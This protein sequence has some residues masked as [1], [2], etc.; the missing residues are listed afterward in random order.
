MSA[1][2]ALERVER[3]A[4]RVK[5][6]NLSGALILGQGASAVELAPFCP[7]RLSHGLLVVN[8]DG[9]SGLG[10]MSPME[11]DEAA[12]SGI[13]LMGPDRLDIARAARDGAP[14]ALLLETAIRRALQLI[15]IAGGDVALA[16]NSPSGDLSEALRVLEKESW[17]FV[18]GHRLVGLERRYKHTSE[19]DEIRRVASVVCTA[20]RE[21]ARM[22]AG[23]SVRGE[24]LELEGS[25]VTIGRLR[26]RA[27]TLFAQAGLEQPEGSLVAAGAEAAVPHNTGDD[28][29]VVGV[30]E[31]VIV[32]LFPRARLFAD[33]TRTFCVGAPPEAL[34]RAHE[35]VADA[36]ALAEAEARSGARGWDLQ[37]A[38][39]Q[40]LG[41]RGYPTPLS[42]PGSTTG[43]VHG[44]GHGVGYELHELPVFSPAGGEHDPAG[45][46]EVGDVLTLEPGLYDPEAGWAVRLE[47]LYVV[48]GD[49][50]E[51]LTELPCDLDPR[52]W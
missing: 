49:G 29:H 37:T 1:E 41:E 42:E 33:C 19:L 16:G 3:L 39:C 40:L 47:N 4:S 9:R 15:G 38:V 45:R 7:G 52:A 20:M 44:L 21:I 2:D 27:S 36:L 5:S 24:T 35:A 32:D 31:S 23:S 17:R 12:S 13:E 43:Y 48:A 46:L 22:L 11:R 14:F 8:A 34:H 10:Y 18:S 51:L 25:P 28:A 50:L 6:A 26:G 30:G